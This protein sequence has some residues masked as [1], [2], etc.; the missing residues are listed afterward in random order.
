MHQAAGNLSNYDCKVQRRTGS[1]QLKPAKI[2]CGLQTITSFIP[3]IPVHEW[4]VLSSDMDSIT[5]IVIV[6]DPN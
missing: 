4:L 6:H 1:K 3:F 5:K 2:E